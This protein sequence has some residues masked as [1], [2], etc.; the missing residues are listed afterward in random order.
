M[1]SE[2]FRLH[3]LYCCNRQEAGREQHNACICWVRGRLGRT[4][5]SLCTLAGDYQVL[6]FECVESVVVFVAARTAC[7]RI[8]LQY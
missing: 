6:S 4:L 2:V 7:L 8:L 3:A 5:G 1:L